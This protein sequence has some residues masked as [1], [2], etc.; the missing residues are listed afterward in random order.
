M[1]GKIVESYMV[2]KEDDPKPYEPKAFI[3]VDLNENSVS[4]LIKNK[5]VLLE[6]NTKRITLG[7]EYRRIEEGRST[8]DREVGRKLREKDKK[9]DVRRKLAKLIVL[10]AYE[11]RSAIILEDLSKRAPEHMVEDVKDKQLRSRI[12]RSAF[13]S[14][15]RAIV[16]KAGE[17]GVPVILVDPSHTS[18]VCP[19]HGTKII[20]QPDGGNAPRVG[21]CGGERWHR[22]VV[23]LYNLRKRVGD[24]SPVPFMSKESH[25]PPTVS[26]WLR[27]K[28]LHLIVIEDKMK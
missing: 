21:V 7:Y 15:R 27:V 1:R 2:F 17:F 22:D 19:V 24:V 4:S 13:S 18:T 23:A 11:S 9:L 6:T 16:E 25:D 8:K 5:P 28:S 14:M 12:Y 26:R 20:Y 3:P 10:E